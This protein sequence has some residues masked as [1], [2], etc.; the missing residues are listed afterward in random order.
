MTEYE[1]IKHI[2]T[3]KEVKEELQKVSGSA[4][5]QNK[6]PDTVDSDTK[7]NVYPSDPHPGLSPVLGS[8]NTLFPGPA[9]ETS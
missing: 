6:T 4:P 8:L 1:L 9:E 3:D 7:E 2:T 5:V